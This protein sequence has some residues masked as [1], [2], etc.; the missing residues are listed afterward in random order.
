M[1]PG[2]HLVTYPLRGGEI[3]NI[4]AVEERQAWA[5]EGWNFKDDPENL[6]AAFAGLCDEVQALLARVEDV[7]LWG[8]FRHPVS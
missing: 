8:L 7:Y 3:L 2:R 1:G 4:V 5:Q 6:R